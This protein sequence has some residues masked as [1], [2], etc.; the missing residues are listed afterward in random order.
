VSHI[1]LEDSRIKDIIKLQ[2][3][4]QY[5]KHFPMSLFQD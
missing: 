1:E 3:F 2:T 4:C 5:K